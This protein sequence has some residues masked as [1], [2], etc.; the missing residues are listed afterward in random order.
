MV[1]L[2]E[3]A[4]IRA[5]VASALSEEGAEKWMRIPRS[6]FGGRTPSEV[7]CAGE[8]ELV[9]ELIEGLLAGSYV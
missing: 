9:E 6:E 3:E 5:W 1:E 2:S 8:V 7:I 4:R